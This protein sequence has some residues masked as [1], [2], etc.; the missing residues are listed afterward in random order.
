MIV[1]AH[2]NYVD[3]VHFGAHTPYNFVI[4]QVAVGKRPL[5]I[6]GR[7]FIINTFPCASLGNVGF[8]RI[9]D[10]PFWVITIQIGRAHV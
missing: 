5:H 9:Q 6:E 3:I 7:S 2:P 8:H 1:T 10:P 4:S